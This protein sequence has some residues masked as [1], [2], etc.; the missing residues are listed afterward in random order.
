[1]NILEEKRQHIL[2]ESS[3]ASSQ[4]ELLDTLDNLLP[5]IDQLVFKEPLHGDVDF[6]VLTD[7]GFHNITSIVFE[8]GDVT[9]IRNLP[10]QITRL[11][12]ANNLLTHLEDLPESLVDLNA[13]GNGLQ[14][15]DLSS[16]KHLKSVK[17]SNNELVSLVLSPSIET[18]LCQ[19]N[20]LQVLDLDNM[21][22]L[23]TLNCNG[24]PLLTITNFQDTIENFFMENNPAL[25]IRRKMDDSA[26]SEK[27]GERIHVDVKEALQ[28]YF[29]MKNEYEMR[30]KED[31]RRLY[32][33]IN[34]KHAKHA[35]HAK[36]VVGEF[37][38]KC[39]YCGR[40][41]GSIF[42]FSQRT[43]KAIC[44]DRQ[45]PC[46][47][48]IEI[49]AGN[50]VDLNYLLNF[51][52]SMVEEQREDIMKIKMD[53]LLNY[54]NEQKSVKKFKKNMEEYNE[55]SETFERFKRDYDDIFFN[56]E[57]EEKIKQKTNRIFERQEKMRKML[58]NLKHGD[59]HDIML[60]YKEEL[61]P[62]YT[63]LQQ[64]KYP[65][66]EILKDDNETTHTLLQKKMNIYYLDYEFGEKNP[67]VNAYIV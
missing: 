10:K 61:L 24:N 54:K 47:F 36:H 34:R 63:Q 43:Y 40:N 53:S 21:D 56:K 16:L 19:N 33:R 28:R 22:A 42:T 46:N 12:I 25:E 65:W 45:N 9:N 18:L 27:K 55:I 1:M 20:Q 6:S 57:I 7:C 17:V 67:I 62:E 4:R 31:R 35:K 38:P 23:K 2:Q 58:D 39:V 11:H 30:A 49:F 41:V 14:Q 29:Q 5:T 44:G 51:Y 52:R 13:A 59:I 15:L 66:A 64:L 8:S 60:F 3:T 50:Y 26:N 32:E 48:H 37:V